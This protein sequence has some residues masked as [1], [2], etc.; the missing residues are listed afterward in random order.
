MSVFD[1]VLI[2]TD[3]DGTILKKDKSISAK[4]L[5]A[6]EYFK[7]NGGIFT[8][9]TGRMPYYICDIGKQIK[10]NAPFGCINGGGLYDYEKKKYIWTNGV[11]ERVLELVEHVD[12]TFPDI[13][14][15]VCTFEKLYFC[16]QNR[17]MEE[18]RKLT[19]VENLACHYRE[20]KEPI[21]KILFGSES[22][23]EIL[24]LKDS[25]NNHPLA[26]EFDFVRSDR[27]LYEILPKDS[28]KGIAIKK[29]C[30]YLNID[31]NK[32][33]AIGDY[34]ND[35]SMFN[36]AKIGIAVSNAC[37]AAK[38]AADYI[39]VSNEEDAIAHIIYDLEKG[40]FL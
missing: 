32:T 18:F 16:K 11:T 28:G 21:A 24:R 38:K 33:I 10:A 2:C 6:I 34:D 25:L 23:D 5:K 4:N 8:F 1:G 14:I 37:D 7:K 40:K 9:V 26:N 19:G 15:Q 29:L 36:A 31:I 3:L 27:E 22:D 35:I 39:T 13:G 30:E 17:T 20:V 12:K